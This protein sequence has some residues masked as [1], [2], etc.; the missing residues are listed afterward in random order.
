M[1]YL[2]GD[3]V[4]FDLG[5]A[6]GS[7]QGGIRC[8]IVVQNNIGNKYSPC[9]I[10]LP[11]TTSESKKHIPTQHRIQLT[12]AYGLILGEQIRTIDKKRITEKGVV[13]HLDDMR[14]VDKALAISVG[15]NIKEVF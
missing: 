1:N 12:N 7:E 11:M 5:Q 8:G 15:L 3:I 10:V 2:R 4:W 9:L 14:M 6:V 13:D